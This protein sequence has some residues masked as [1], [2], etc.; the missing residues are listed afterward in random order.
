MNLLKKTIR[1]KVTAAVLMLNALLMDAQAG[2]LQVFWIDKDGTSH[3]EPIEYLVPGTPHDAIFKK[4]Y[5]ERADGNYVADSCQIRTRT[6]E[7]KR[8]QPAPAEASKSQPHRRAELPVPGAGHFD[9]SRIVDADVGDGLPSLR[10]LKPILPDTEVSPDL[11]V[12]EQAQSLGWSSSGQDSDST[13]LKAEQALAETRAQE[14]RARRDTQLQNTVARYEAGA[15]VGT[16]PT[17]ELREV[18]REA[19][20]GLGSLGDVLRA[21]ADRMEQPRAVEPIA[22]PADTLPRETLTEILAPLASPGL[23]PLQI[24]AGVAE[25]E[26]RIMG[27]NAAGDPSLESSAQYLNQILG[28]K[29]IDNQGLLKNLAQVNAVERNLIS[30]RH[31]P[32][33]HSLRKAL[34]ET[35]AATSVVLS[36]CAENLGGAAPCVEVKQWA[37]ELIAG[38]TDLD[39]VAAYGDPAITRSIQSELDRS[40]DSL[41]RIAQ[42]AVAGAGDLPTQLDGLSEQTPVVSHGIGMILSETPKLS[43]AIQTNA[44]ENYERYLS[45]TS[46]ERQELSYAFAQDLFTGSF[47]SDAAVTSGSPRVN[48]LRDALLSHS[49]T[50]ANQNAER[51][52]QGAE[53]RRLLQ[54]RLRLI[55]DPGL[56]NLGYEFQ[57][58]PGEIHDEIVREYQ[59]LYKFQPQGKTQKIARGLGLSATRAADQALARGVSEDAHFY[60]ELGKSMLDLT[61]GLDPITGFGRSAYELATGKNLIT[62]EKLGGLDRALAFVGVLSLGT[63]NTA[64]KATRMAH[65]FQGAARILRE[66]P[67]IQVAIRD[68]KILAQKVEHLL[69]GMTKSSRVSAIHTAEHVNHHYSPRFARYTAAGTPPFEWGTHVVEGQI[70]RKDSKFVRLHAENAPASGW[71]MKKSA[72]EG[73]TAE[74]IKVKFALPGHVTHVSDIHVPKGEKF[75]RGSVQDHGRGTSGA[76]QYYFPN[77]HQDWFRNTRRF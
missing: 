3:K 61:V 32:E 66:K 62:G 30:N 43:E 25:V 35:L 72:I 44:A 71:V 68:G 56:A 67:A 70:M 75:L 31:T 18:Q 2:I 76:I 69:P 29:W 13:Q 57:S 74:Q 63:A 6:P 11:R 45:S 50:V 64:V 42:S 37:D 19:Y 52:G 16:A 41:S 33:G 5:R 55:P 47:A 27:F 36:R 12:H 28:S 58:A 23:N 17:V 10:D 65:I 53:A 59:D 20:T 15:R 26:E 48:G 24:S 38:Y 51:D 22:V 60:H 4:C 21:A 54:E 9:L 77:A 73:L 34:N 1:N 40:K 46:E 8:A 7:V 14:E 49:I 39:R